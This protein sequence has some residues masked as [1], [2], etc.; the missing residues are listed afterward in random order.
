MIIMM[1]DIQILSE[2][3]VVVI[4][5][6]E[7]VLHS[8]DEVIDKFRPGDDWL[9]NSMQRNMDLDQVAFTYLKYFG[10]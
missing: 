9:L 7:L 5:A 8:Y 6:I 1:N 10:D 2:S 3:H 4:K